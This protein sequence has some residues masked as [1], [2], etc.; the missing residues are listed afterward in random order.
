MLEGSIQARGA[1]TIGLQTKGGKGAEP[2]ESWQGNEVRINSE[3]GQQKVYQ[4]QEWI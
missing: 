3:T 2:R 1:D 4:E